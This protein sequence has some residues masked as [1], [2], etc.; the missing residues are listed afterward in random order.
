MELNCLAVKKIFSPNL[1][2]YILHWFY[3]NITEHPDTM[4][5]TELTTVT[6]YLLYVSKNI[7]PANQRQE[8]TPNSQYKQIMHKEK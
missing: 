4:Q 3:Q 2:L 6:T 1:K 7:F 5:N 8:L